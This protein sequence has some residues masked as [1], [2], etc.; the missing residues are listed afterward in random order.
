LANLIVTFGVLSLPSPIMDAR[1]KRTEKVA[2]GGGGSV[3][4]M[5]ATRENVADLY[6]EAACWVEVGPAPVAADPSSSVGES[7]FM[8]EGERLQAH[9]ESGSKVAA[10]AAA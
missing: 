2:L 9:L 7:W 8:A 5:H 1:P 10:V 6:A 3:T 4:T